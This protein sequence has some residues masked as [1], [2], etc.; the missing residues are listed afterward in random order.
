MATKA[1][2]QATESGQERFG[3]Y[4]AAR[5]KKDR[6]SGLEDSVGYPVLADTML[7]NG[8]HDL[9]QAINRAPEAVAG[10]TLSHRSAAGKWPSRNAGA[11]VG[12]KKSFSQQDP[13]HHDGPVSRHAGNV[14]APGK[15][16]AQSA[17]AAREDKL[18]VRAGSLTLAD[19]QAAKRFIETGQPPLEGAYGN[20][21]LRK[22]VINGAGN[23]TNKFLVGRVK[24]DGKL[25]I[26][27]KPATGKV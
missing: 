16:L 23:S 21:Y 10:L 11:G 8:E 6:D 20:L 14:V 25:P 3:A 19:G 2:K 4:L 22:D 9:S 15:T 26:K 1:A 27:D 5:A 24:A 7:L 17:T 18:L 12:E 13:K